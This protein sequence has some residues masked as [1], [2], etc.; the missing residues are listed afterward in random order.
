[1]K[2]KKSAKTQ[3]KRVAMGEAP[4]APTSFPEAN[5]KMPSGHT[6]MSTNYTIHSS[7]L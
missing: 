6:K 2:Q 7:A 4:P 3:P 1:M 5:N